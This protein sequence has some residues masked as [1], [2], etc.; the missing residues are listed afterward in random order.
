MAE[1]SRRLLAFR[2]LARPAA[3]ESLAS[4]RIGLS[5]RHWRTHL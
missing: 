3:P 5:N 4:G 1:R 2:T